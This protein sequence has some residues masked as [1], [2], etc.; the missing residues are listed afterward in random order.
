MYVLI[1]CYFLSN[2]II[3]KKPKQVMICTLTIFIIFVKLNALDNF[4]TL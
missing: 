3:L 1:V 4:K 2:K